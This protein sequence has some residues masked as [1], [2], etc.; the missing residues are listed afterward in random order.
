M[1]ARIAIVVPT[2]RPERVDGFLHAWRGLILKNL[3]TLY[4]VFDES[5]VRI[6]VFPFGKFKE[7]RTPDP[8]FMKLIHTETDAVRNIGFVEVIKDGAQIIVTLDDDVLP[9]DDRDAISEHVEALRGKHPTSWFNPYS[10]FMRGFPYCV[11]EE[12]QAAVSHGIWSGSLDFDSVAEISGCGVYEQFSYKGAIP[13][14]AMI[15]LCGMNLAFTRAVAPHV[16]FAPMGGKTGFNRFAD[17]WMGMNLKNRLDE[18]NL[19][20]VHGYSMVYHNRQSDKFDNLKAEAAGIRE[21]ELLNSGK[22]DKLNHKYWAM[23][24]SKRKQWAKKM[25]G[26]I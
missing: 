25:K 8:E 9:M 6:G 21:H 20:M 16:Y 18:L 13:K 7:F 15:P 19:A 5:P 4:I 14:W 2:N 10:N 11:R 24:E 12:S 22:L 17:I 26:L 23:Y 1:S 3:A